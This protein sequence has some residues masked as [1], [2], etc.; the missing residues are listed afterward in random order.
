M[1]RQAPLLCFAL[2]IWAYSSGIS[3]G[4]CAYERKRRLKNPSGIEAVPA[5]LPLAGGECIL[6][7]PARATFVAVSHS[8]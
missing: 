7:G 5:G 3:N 6:V 4:C 8:Q 2:P 1:S